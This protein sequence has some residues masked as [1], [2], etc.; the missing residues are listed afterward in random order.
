MANAKAA[1]RRLGA[2]SIATAKDV[3][4]ERG[5]GRIRRADTADQ[6]VGEVRIVLLE[7]PFEGEAAFPTGLIPGALDPAHE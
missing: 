1:S 4:D 5:M 7:L 6:P 3:I 2:S